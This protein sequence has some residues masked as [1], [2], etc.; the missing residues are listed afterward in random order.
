MTLETTYRVERAKWDALAQRKQ[1]D[2][3]IFLLEENFQT[4]AQQASTMAGVIEFLGDLHGKQVLEYGCGLGK[5]AVL[6]AK[7]GAQ[8]TTF[9]LSPT[10]VAVTRNRATQ[11]ELQT[12]INLTVAAGEHLPYADES[13]DVIFGRAILHHI[14]ADLGWHELDRMLKSGGKAVFIEPMGM[15]P[16][17][18][19]ARDHIPYPGKNPRGADRPLTYQEINTWGKG[20]RKVYYQ[21]MQLFSMLERGLGFHKRLQVLRYFDRQLLTVFP[22]LRRYCRYVAIFMVK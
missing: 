13:F 12:N 1:S 21:E 15:N 9:D 17:L 10:S 8:V 3:G 7:S 22:G 2:A 11:N 16:L 19:F 14:D 20:F 4:Y 6:L 5:T 18:N